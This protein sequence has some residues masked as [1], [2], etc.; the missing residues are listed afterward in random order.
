MQRPTIP[1]RRS[2]HPAAL[3]A[4]G[5][6]I[7][8]WLS[9]ASAGAALSSAPDPPTWVPVNGPVRAFA[10]L[11]GTTYVGGEFTQVG[12]LVGPGIVYG[13]QSELPE[14]SWP[15]IQGVVT[16]S[17]SDG[18]GGWYVAGNLD[19]VGET[20][21]T[22][23]VHIT[24]D[25]RLDARFNPPAPPQT[26]TFGQV[27]AMAVS[28][29]TVYVGG[30]SYVAAYSRTSGALLWAVEPNGQA[31]AL[32]LSGGTLYAGGAFTSIRDG[33]TD[34]ERQ[35]LAALN[36]ST[37][38]ISQTWNPQANEPVS[39]LVSSGST[40]YAGG[41]FTIVNG[42][43]VREHLAAFD[44]TTGTATEWNPDVNSSA[45]A[46]AVEG[47]RVYAGGQFTEVNGSVVRNHAAAFNA[48]T[49]AA[50]GWNPDLDESVYALATSG[51]TVLA[52]GRFK[53]VNGGV[54]RSYLASFNNTDGTATSWN[55]SLEYFA[56]TLASSGAELFVGGTF[57]CAGVTTR[58]D[59]FAY[60]KEGEALPWNPDVNGAVDAL[61]ASG[62]TI[63]AGGAFTRVNQGGLDPE[64]KHLAA[65]NEEG[66]ALEWDPDVNGQ[67]DALALSGSTI[68]AGGTF[69]EVNGTTHRASLAAFSTTGG[70]QVVA[71]WNPELAGGSEAVDA[72]ALSGSALYVGGSF[73]F[74]D[75]RDAAAFTLAGTPSAELTTWNPSPDGT[76]YALLAAN[77]T[78]YAGGEF[79][80]ANTATVSVARSHA[81][82][83]DPTSGSVTSWNP[84]V[85][86][87]VYA[88]AA[89][90]GEILVAGHFYDVNGLPGETDH[91]VGVDALGGTLG[92]WA[93]EPNTDGTVF[94][95]LPDAPGPEGRGGLSVGGEFFSFSQEAQEFEA[96]HYAYFSVL[97][98]PA[99]NE[100]PTVSGNP[101]AG[102]TLSAQNGSWTGSRPLTYAFQ[103]QRCNGEGAECVNVEG[104]NGETFLLGATDGDHT[105][106]VI[107]TAKN[108]GGSESATSA[109]TGPVTAEPPVIAANPP[110]SAPARSPAPAPRLTAALADASSAIVRGGRTRISCA[111]NAGAIRSC[112]LLAR[113]RFAGHLRT[114]GTGAYRALPGSPGGPSAHL[115]LKLNALG[116]RALHAHP[117]GLRLTLSVIATPSG[118]STWDAGALTSKRTVVVYAS[119]QTVDTPSDSFRLSSAAPSAALE[120]SL[121][122][123]ADRLGPVREIICTGRASTGSSPAGGLTLGL[124]RARVACDVL[125]HALPGVRYLYT[126]VPVAPRSPAASSAGNRERGYVEVTIIR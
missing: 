100:L 74:T 49:G 76:V 20:E 95:I 23:V 99:S 2:A 114:V 83:F 69:T 116:M 9:C 97:Q 54:A 65:F 119:R 101:A 102:Q 13:A 72:L 66:V 92:E 104:A 45:L 52:G 111:V 94:A 121:H 86:G 96:I 10:R 44:G 15:S 42:S 55:P 62:S 26:G 88:L 126:A 29:T 67:V 28:A 59:L 89:L 77:S 115:A 125:D 60:N 41:A 48:E 34:T 37:G 19:K 64:I 103:W 1:P 30:P 25:R 105:I 68:Y 14:S 70:G 85:E 57:L 35:R 81:A 122:I 110:T 22:N 17:A 98:A 109:A 113:A 82:A 108:R 107:E 40:V 43:T 118:A 24:A 106:R 90:G 3:L 50:T 36:A 56:A 112:T 6:A 93:P 123:L 91:L 84:D 53:H 46:L 58:D 16:E 11:A 117:H 87:P 32:T 80:R 38:A 63:Y 71:T 21:V 8:L 73:E 124:T 5:T 7:C 51:Q 18:E 78:I 12:K 47:S 4:A 31:D 39:A 27:S 61:A 75:R 33:E 79:E 120:R